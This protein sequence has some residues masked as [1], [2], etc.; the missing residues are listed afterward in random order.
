MMEARGRPMTPGEDRLVAVLTMLRDQL[1]PVVDQIAAGHLTPDQ[2]LQLAAM[3]ELVARDLR[4]TVVPP[5]DT[6]DSGG[7]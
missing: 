7:R 2:A 3:L 4:P 5:D 1:A 6:G